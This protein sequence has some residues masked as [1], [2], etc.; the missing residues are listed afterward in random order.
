MKEKPAT[1]ASRDL[2][3]EN[4]SLRR[5]IKV[6]MHWAQDNEERM[7]RF[8]AQELRLLG[9][10]SLYELLLMVIHETRVKF[11]LDIITLALVDGD[12]EIRHL[13]QHTGVQL[14]EMPQVVFLDRP[15]E[16]GG[17]FEERLEPRLA[18]YRPDSM[19]ALFPDPCTQPASVAILPLVREG[20]I[21]GSLNLGS[22]DAERYRGTLPADF[23]AHF[24]AVVAVCLENALNHERLKLVGLTDTLTSVYNRRY[25]DQRFAE[26]LRRVKRECHPLS[27]LFLD[28]DHF[29]RVN[30]NYG[31]TVG[32][33]VLQGVARIIKAHLRNVDI[34]ARYGGEEFVALLPGTAVAEAAA[35]AERIRQALEEKVFAHP[36]FDPFRVTLSIGVGALPGEAGLSDPEQSGKRLLEAADGALYQAKGSGRNCVVSAGEVA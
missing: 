23:L 29:K 2:E 4:R 30:D 8:Q 21:I 5:R 31:H 9:I 7:R 16:L 13:L 27:C 22:E 14:E 25:F 28:V 6:L 15:D 17:F 26:E 1:T 24:G 36:G 34:L 20:R 10:A 35:I 19:G 33:Y 18:R 32:D 12:H 3:S 11:K